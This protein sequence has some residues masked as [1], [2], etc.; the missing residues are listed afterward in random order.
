MNGKCDTL[1]RYSRLAINGLCADIRACCLL[2]SR[3]IVCGDDGPWGRVW[4]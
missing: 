4:I 1:N 2:A 3:F